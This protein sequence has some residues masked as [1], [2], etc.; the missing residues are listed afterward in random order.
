MER[1]ENRRK[2]EPTAWAI[3]SVGQDS[4]FLFLLH[5]AVE[6]PRQNRRE[7]DSRGGSRKTAKHP[8]E[9]RMDND[10]SP[11]TGQEK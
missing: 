2:P 5:A 4:P 11:K 9:S 8:A 6:F 3:L 1:R 7:S 10:P